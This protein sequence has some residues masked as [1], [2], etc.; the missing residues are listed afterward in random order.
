MELGCG[1]LTFPAKPGCPRPSQVSEGDPCDHTLLSLTANAIMSHTSFHSAGCVLHE[2]CG[3]APCTSESDSPC[4]SHSRPIVR[5]SDACCP[6]PPYE[7]SSTLRLGG[8]GT[9]GHILHVASG[10]KPSEASPADPCG[11]KRLRPDWEHG[12]CGRG[13]HV[14]LSSSCLGLPCSVSSVLHTASGGSSLP[15]FHE[16]D[17]CLQTLPQPLSPPLPSVAAIHDHGHVPAMLRVSVS[18][19]NSTPLQYIA[20]LE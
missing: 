2:A 20:S 12:P 6:S 7:P 16:F 1:E 17:G 18:R 14:E 11:Q 3:G 19:V 10:G 13:P 5:K 15:P 9:N 4:G 8:M